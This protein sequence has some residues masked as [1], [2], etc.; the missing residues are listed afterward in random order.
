MEQFSPFLF[1][2]KRYDIIVL[3]CSIVLKPFLIYEINFC[4]VLDFCVLSASL[5]LFKF[6]HVII[7]GNLLCISSEF[8]L[9]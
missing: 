4:P 3:N 9:I 5:K 2:L 6:Q 8:C 7:L 1:V